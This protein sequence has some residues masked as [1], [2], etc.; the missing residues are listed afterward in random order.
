MP[1]IFIIDFHVKDHIQRQDPCPRDSVTSCRSVWF[2]LIAIN[3]DCISG[4]KVITI[5]SL[6]MAVGK[7]SRRHIQTFYFKYK[8]E[9]FFSRYSMNGLCE[10][11]LPV[12]TSTSFEAG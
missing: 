7:G 8:G 3:V 12:I 4:M 2:K 1:V 10:S 11:G 6:S 5:A 9:N